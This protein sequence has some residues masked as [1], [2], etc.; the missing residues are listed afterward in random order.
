MTLAR[1]ALAAMALAIGAGGAL[2][3]SA[4]TPLGQFNDWA[5]YSGQNSG[6]KVCYILSQPKSSEPQGV[7]RDPIY[8]FVTARPGQD[9]DSEVSIIMGYPLQPN[10]TP[11]VTVD[12]TS[13]D[14]FAK[15]DSAWVANAAEER[16]LVAAM[17]AGRDM[18]VRGTST[19]GT[20]T[21]DTYSLSGV[22]AAHNR[23]QQECR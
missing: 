21:T 7:N 20:N 13:F 18:S 14:L 10:S 2:A 12:G 15:N 1:L 8:F 23:I 9:V 22:T 5:A 16:R 19:R 3:Q 11:T 6:N 17:R 4:P